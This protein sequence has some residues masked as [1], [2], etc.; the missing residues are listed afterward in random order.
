MK[1][2]K[3]PSLQLS[4]DF[5]ATTVASQFSKADF[6]PVSVLYVKSEKA[7]INR[8]PEKTAPLTMAG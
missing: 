7:Q 2:K 4:L 8:L 3:V 5:A 1:L 6:K